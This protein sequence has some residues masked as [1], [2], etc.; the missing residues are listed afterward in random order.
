[1]YADSFL[2]SANTDMAASLAATIQTDPPTTL[3]NQAKETASV[4]CKCWVAL[5]RQILTILQ[6][7]KYSIIYVIVVSLLAALIVLRELRN[8]NC[9]TTQADVSRVAALFRDRITF[10]C[11]IC[12]SI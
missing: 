10:E 1:M 6:V 5:L 12:K 8:S 11:S 2:L 9:M 7:I 4:D 3:L